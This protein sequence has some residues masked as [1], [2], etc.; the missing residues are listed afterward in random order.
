MAVVLLLLVACGEEGGSVDQGQNQGGGGDPNC[1]EEQFTSPS[2]LG[3]L[4]TNCGDGT[5]ASSGATVSVHYVGT[6]E[7]GEQFDSSRDR[8]QPFQFVLGSGQVIP[9]WDEGI[10]GMKVGGTRTLTIPPDLGYG[11]AGSPPVIPPNATLIFEVEL[12]DV[13]QAPA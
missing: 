7:S 4:D 1:H 6:L 12:M 11:A 10:Q 9:G 8:G 2:G 3:I 13:Q 5:E